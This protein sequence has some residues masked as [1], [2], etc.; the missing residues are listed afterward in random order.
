MG[1]GMS[2]TDFLAYLLFIVV[3]VTLIVWHL[4]VKW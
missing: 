3:F 2:Y 4:K 1:Q